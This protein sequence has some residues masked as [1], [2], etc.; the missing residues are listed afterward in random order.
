M[1]IDKGTDI[2]ERLKKLVIKRK[3]QIVESKRIVGYR[4][5][6]TSTG[7]VSAESYSFNLDE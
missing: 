6:R 2:T 7:S 5:R 3:T 4:P 1:Y